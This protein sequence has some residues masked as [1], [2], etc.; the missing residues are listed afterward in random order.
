MT[1]MFAGNDEFNNGAYPNGMG[2]QYP[3][4]WDTSSVTNMDRMFVNATVF[5]QDI[6]N[7]DVSSVTNM[8][9][10]FYG[11]QRFNQDISGWCVTNITSEPSG[12]DDNR[13]SPITSPP[14]WGTCPPPTSNA[15][16]TISSSDSDNIITSGVVTLTATFSENMAATPLVSIAGLVTN[17]AMIQGASAAEWTYYWQVPLQVVIL[18]ITTG[19]VTTNLCS[20]GSCNRYNFSYL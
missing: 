11:A 10:M 8:Y 2:P 12:F 14:V 20:Y 15:T 1:F 13:F 18:Q 19:T 3:L 7:W 17:T 5:N 16:L 4:D 9:W 6:G